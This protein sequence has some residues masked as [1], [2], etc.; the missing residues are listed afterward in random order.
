MAIVLDTASGTSDSDTTGITQSVTVGNNTNRRLTVVVASNGAAD[1]P[2]SVSSVTYAGSSL[3]RQV[4]LASNQPGNENMVEIWEMVAPATGANNLVVTMAAMC[5]F[6]DIG[7]V[8]THGSSQTITPDSTNSD[9]T[10]SQN[11]AVTT[12]SVVDNAWA[13]SIGYPTDNPSQGITGATEFM[14]SFFPDAGYS[15]PKT[16]SGL[17]T[18]TYGGLAGGETWVWCIVSI[19][20]F[21]ETP[22]ITYV[23][24]KKH[25]WY[26]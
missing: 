2:V 20:P 23:T 14:G 16:P 11:A 6:L 18:H 10:S 9:N 4:S 1:D 24:S 25:P 8:S 26:H 22:T 15:G 19:A 3:T 7:W 12:T 17:I 5:D 13:V 21:V